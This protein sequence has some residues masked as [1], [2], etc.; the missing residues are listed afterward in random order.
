MDIA[1]ATRWSHLD[2]DIRLVEGTNAISLALPAGTNAQSI[3]RLPNVRPW[4]SSIIGTLGDPAFIGQLQTGTIQ[5][6]GQRR[7]YGRLLGSRDPSLIRNA[8]QTQITALTD[9]LVGEKR[10]VMPPSTIYL[11]SPIAMLAIP[12]S[13]FSS[14]I[15]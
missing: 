7:R 5:G 10:K 14:P 11:P 15:G 13:A 9:G 3:C 4:I 2:K 8:I 6:A 12:S 1:G